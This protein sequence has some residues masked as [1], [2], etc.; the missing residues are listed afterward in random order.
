M[1]RGLRLAI[2]FEDEEYAGIARNIGV[3]SEIG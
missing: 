1:P 2:E 3:K